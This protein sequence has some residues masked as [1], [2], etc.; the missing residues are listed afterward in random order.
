MANY[1]DMNIDLPKLVNPEKIQQNLDK[2]NLI[3]FYENNKDRFFNKIEKD[4]NWQTKKE[5]KIVEIEEIPGIFFKINKDIKYDDYNNEINYKTKCNNTIDS[6]DDNKSTFYN[7]FYQMYVDITRDNFYYKKSKNIMSMDIK[8]NDDLKKNDKSKQLIQCFDKYFDILSDSLGDKNLY[9]EYQLYMAPH[10]ISYDENSSGLL[11]TLIPEKINKQIK[12]NNDVL[13]YNQ[14]KVYSNNNN[15]NNNNYTISRR[16]N[17]NSIGRS[18]STSRS[19]SRSSSRRSSSTSSYNRRPSTST[20]T[21]INTGTGTS[22]RRSSRRS[23]SSN[24]RL[25]SNFNK[26]INKTKKTCPLDVDASLCINIGKKFSELELNDDTIIN[27]KIQNILYKISFVNQ[28]YSGFSNYFVHV[29]DL[30]ILI[31]TLKKLLKWVIL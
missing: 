22:R 2:F 8:K 5:D 23:I 13:Y 26:P 20:R 19:S 27:N 17:R 9:N 25:T 21:I 30:Y 29:I 15:N 31:V 12:K 24:S 16:S 4:N 10:L 3:N 18:R 1:M 28:N 11:T 6:K 14:D 7:F